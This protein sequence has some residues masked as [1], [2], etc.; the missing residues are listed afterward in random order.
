MPSH[1]EGRKVDSANQRVGVRI[2][3]PI[4]HRAPYLTQ[5]ALDTRYSLAMTGPRLYPH[6]VHTFPPGVL[7]AEGSGPEFRE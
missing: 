2:Y 4:V 7:K 6:A 5:P 1:I 3:I